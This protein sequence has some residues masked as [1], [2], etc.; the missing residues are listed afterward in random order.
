MWCLYNM[1]DFIQTTVTQNQ[2]PVSLTVI[3]SQFKFDGNFVSLSCRS[4]TMIATKFCTWHDSWAVVACAKICCALMASNGVMA[5]RSFPRIWIA[6]KNRYWNGP[7]V[8]VVDIWDMPCELNVCY[9]YMPVCYDKLFLAVL[10]YWSYYGLDSNCC[11]MQSQQTQHDL[12][13]RTLYAV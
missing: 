1:V 12:P 7:L 4:N 9:I 11:P 5:R 8:C 2:G 10:L 13:V 6:G 3:P